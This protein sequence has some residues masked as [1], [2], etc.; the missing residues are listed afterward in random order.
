[1]LA[2]AREEL[3]AVDAADAFRRAWRERLV[4]G[5][6]DGGRGRRGALR[7]FLEQEAAE[8]CGRRVE[9]LE[10]RVEI[11]IAG[12]K[13]HGALD[14]VDADLAPG[15]DGRR[16]FVVLDYKTGRFVPT[17]EKV[18]EGR[19]LQLPFYALAAAH[20]LGAGFR[21]VGA[22]YYPIALDPRRRP[23]RPWRLEGA[24]LEAALARAPQAI[25]AAIAAVRA[26]IF[27]P[28]WLPPGE[29]GCGYCDYARVCRVDHARMEALAERGAP[30]IF[31]PLPLVEERP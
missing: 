28:G 17:R 19:A 27:H 13:V 12:T 29:K 10:A 1:M 11:E 20:A 18:C 9:R 4:A 24:A 2:I 22:A 21:P 31:R 6:E 7:L 5:L 25:G 23:P 3:A 14:R 8:A 30:G 26:G 15:P 16:G